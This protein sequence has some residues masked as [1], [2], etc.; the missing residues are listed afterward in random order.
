M[1]CDCEDYP[2]C[3]CEPQTQRQK[4]NDRAQEEYERAN[5][6]MERGICLAENPDQD[7]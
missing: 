4:A 2:A 7:G 1:R 5:N 6:E 3:G